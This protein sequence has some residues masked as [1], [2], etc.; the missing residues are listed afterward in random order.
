MLG[1]IP[2]SPN[3]PSWCDAQLKNAQEQLYKFVVKAKEMYAL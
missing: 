2:P 3:M 1:A